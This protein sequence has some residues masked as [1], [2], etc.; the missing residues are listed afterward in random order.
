MVGVRAVQQTSELKGNQFFPCSFSSG[1]EVGMGGLAASSCPLENRDYML[2]PDGG[3]STGSEGS[4]R[5]PLRRTV[6]S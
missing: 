4:N 2:M 1:K 6:D 3:D 5:P